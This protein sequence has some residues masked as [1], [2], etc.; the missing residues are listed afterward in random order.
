MFGYTNS[1]WTLKVGL[2]CEHFCRLLAHM[3]AHGQTICYPQL[4]GPMETRPL[5]EVTSGYVKRAAGLFPHQGTE[6]SW[7]TSME[8]RTDH[9]L[10]REGSVDDDNLRFATS[11]QA[12]AL[13]PALAG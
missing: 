5:L 8:Y 3:D 4:P 9:K 2:V 1:S 13:E 10:L 6:G 7:R 11:S 12:D